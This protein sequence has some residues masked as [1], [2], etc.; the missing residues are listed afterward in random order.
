MNQI[1][2][3]FC[4]GHRPTNGKRCLGC[5]MEIKAATT[6]D[7]TLNPPKCVRCWGYRV[8]AIDGDRWHCRECG[9][10]FDVPKRKPRPDKR[11]RIA[12]AEERKKRNQ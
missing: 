5:G 1:N 6:P 4:A 7:V 10:V 11:K 9:S 8:T 2:C 3:R 12:A